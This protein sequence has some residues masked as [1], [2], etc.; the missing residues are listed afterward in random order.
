MKN[1]EKLAEKITNELLSLLEIKAKGLATSDAANNIRV[2]I[3]S[4]DPGILI[5]YHG[6]T[7]R[8]IQTIIGLIVFRKVG[9]WLRIIV[10][11]GNYREEREVKLGELARRSAERARF[12]AKAVVMPRMP[13]DDR[14]MIHLAV[15][16]IE[17]VFSESV[18][19]GQQRRVVIKPEEENTKESLV[20]ESLG[21]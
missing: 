10:D 16:K 12:L 19:E 18:G 8:A 14:R 1:K 13:P 9:E 11:V 3:E 4:E 17:G 6:E 7:L 5:G 20:N 2:N 21:Q 15:S